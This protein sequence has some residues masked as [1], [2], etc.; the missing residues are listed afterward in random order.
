MFGVIVCVALPFS[1]VASPID[2][3]V[4][5]SQHPITD[6]DL[7]ALKQLGLTDPLEVLVEDLRAHPELIPYE[8]IH[9]GTMAFYNPTAIRVLTRRWVLAAFDDGHIGGYLLLSFEV[10]E[11]KTIKWRVIDAHES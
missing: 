10:S 11:D 9:G 8:G 5:R 3:E 6:S 7:F 1:D 2:K 4:L